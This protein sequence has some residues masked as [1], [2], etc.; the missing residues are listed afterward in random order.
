MMN[1]IGNSHWK[2]PLG[3]YEKAID[4]LRRARERFQEEFQI[5]KVTY[6]QTLES[7]LQTYQSE[8]NA[9]KSE[10]YTTR[11]RLVNAEKAAQEAQIKLIDV[12]NVAN[13]AQTELRAIKEDMTERTI[14]SQIIDEITQIK[15]QLSQL[16]S[17]TK[18]D[19]SDMESQ[20][21]QSL[22][23][24]QL[25]CT[26]LEAE[27][28]LVSPASG[29]D[30]TKL[31]ELLVEKKWDEADKETYTLMLKVAEREGE[32]WLDD[33]NI[34]NFPRHDL[35]IIN[36]LWLKYSNGQF[37]FSVQK[38]IWR[39]AN[40]DYKRFGDR[41][42]WLANLVNSEWLK[43]ENY[44]F[45]LNA[46]EGHLPSTVQVVGLGR[47]NLGGLQHRLKIFLSRY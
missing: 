40:E 34:K 25:Q 5:L 14:N 6:T 42:G 11:E 15:E 35:R 18:R 26:R 1:N 3:C 29:I 43:Y 32:R 36:N 38:R 17:L 16:H 12:E 7:N 13:A 28:T 20:I 22:S 27:L 47:G 10:L 19:S 8:I 31:Q 45:S 41:V 9:L 46:P 44:D 21:L 30:Y 37:G 23:A 39:D 2:T 24:L 33:G 4:D